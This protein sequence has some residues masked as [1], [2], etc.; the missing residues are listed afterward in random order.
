MQTYYER[1]REHEE[2]LSL[3]GIE[4]EVH[5]SLRRERLDWATGVSLIAPLEVRNETELALVAD[6]ARRLLLGRT[7][8]EEEFPNYRYGKS[9]WIAE[10]DQRRPA[11]IE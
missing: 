8:L 5:A 9:D 2:K 7:R 11:K 4:C 6:L 1:L 10:S 3:E